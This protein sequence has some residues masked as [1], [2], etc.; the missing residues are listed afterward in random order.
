MSKT[1]MSD[2]QIR[3]ANLLIGEIAIKHGYT[4]KDLTGKRRHRKLCRVR[5]EAVYWLVEDLELSYPKIGWLLNR[6]HST[7]MFSYKNHQDLLVKGNP[8]TE[9]R[10]WELIL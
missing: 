7:M 2:I 3:E 5:D 1:R 6:D 9:K 4:F 10:V 8:L